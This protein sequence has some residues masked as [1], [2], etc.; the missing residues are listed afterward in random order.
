MTDSDLEKFG[1]I[2]GA[3]AEAFRANITSA[4]ILAYKMALG[5]LPIESIES[6]ALKAMRE[7]TFMPPASERRTTALCGGMGVDER[8]EKAWQVLD[9]TLKRHGYDR[10]IAFDDPALTAAVRSLG[11]LERLCKIPDDEFHKW[12]KKEFANTYGTLVRSPPSPEACQPL[13]G[14]FDREN[15]RLGYYGNMQDPLLI[16]S[17][18]PAIPN[19]P[20]V[21]ELLG[22]Q[23]QSRKLLAEVRAEAGAA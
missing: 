19:A 7:A 10:T 6:A 22:K 15:S 12:T 4:T 9:T 21:R 23:D 17:K 14:W 1:N 18:L 3:L 16:E 2:I 11:G 5:D 13:L 20:N 8:T